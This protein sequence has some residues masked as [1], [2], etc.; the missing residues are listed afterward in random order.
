MTD[1]NERKWESDTPQ[2]AGWWQASNGKW[3][4]P[5]SAPQRPDGKRHTHQQS[6]F[7]P[8]GPR[9]AHWLADRAGW[10]ILFIIVLCAVAYP[11][12][13][14]RAPT[15]IR[16]LFGVALVSLIIFGG[17]RFWKNL[18]AGSRRD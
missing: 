12:S 7:S 2:G 5:E 9:W 8:G 17:V 10:V 13:F 15:P 6:D 4:P 14:G 1:R 16:M 11:E 3:Y 18:G